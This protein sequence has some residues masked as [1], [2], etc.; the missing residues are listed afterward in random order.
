MTQPTSRLV[1]LAPPE[2]TAGFHLAGVEV[3]SVQSLVETEEELRR[4]EQQDE[5][6]VIAVY[7]PFLEQLD[8]DLAHRLESTLQ[9][10]VVA[11]PTGL[12]SRT[13]GDRR[14]RLMERLQRAVG[15]HITF[16]GEE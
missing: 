15:Y 10:V 13:E 14:A 6:G 16:G 1:V 4:L 11:L 8:P 12:G 9:P 3:R 7:R 5:Q 2:L